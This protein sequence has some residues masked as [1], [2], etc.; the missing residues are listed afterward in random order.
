MEPQAQAPAPP[1]PE[2]T[3]RREAIDLIRSNRE[4]IYW[5]VL[6]MLGIH[7]SLESNQDEL[8]AQADRIARWLERDIHRSHF[9]PPPRPI[10]KRALDDLRSIECHVRLCAAR[11]PGYPVLPRERCRHLLRRLLRK[12]RVRLGLYRLKDR[13]I[14]YARTYQGWF[15]YWFFEARH[16]LGVAEEAER[17]AAQG[18]LLSVMFPYLNVPAETWPPIEVPTTCRDALARIEER[19]ALVRWPSD[20]DP[21]ILLDR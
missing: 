10:S 11:Y 16:E 6:R 3:R 7:L 14:H 21:P 2:D 17:A 8:I 13:V 4:R 12:R 9:P 1:A 15:R 20:L 18:K 19:P 5:I